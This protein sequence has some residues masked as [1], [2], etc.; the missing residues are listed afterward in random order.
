MTQPTEIPNEET[1]KVYWIGDPEV[2]AVSVGAIDNLVIKSGGMD[3]PISVAV[4]L[5][6]TQPKSFSPVP[7]Q[8][9]K[10]TPEKSTPKPL[11]E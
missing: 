5:T 10:A 11:E 1:T 7:P 9:V 3:V 4:Y 8:P 6:S 2:T